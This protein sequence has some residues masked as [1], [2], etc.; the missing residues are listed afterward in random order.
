VGSLFENKKCLFSI[1]V[2]FLLGILVG[3]GLAKYFPGPKP[4]PVPASISGTVWRD[5]TADASTNPHSTCE[6]GSGSAQTNITVRFDIN[7]DGQAGY[8]EVINVP[9]P[10]GTFTLGP[11]ITPG[12]YRIRAMST[13]GSGWCDFDNQA[14]AGAP[15]QNGVLL[16]VPQTGYSDVSG[17]NFGYK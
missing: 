6:L 13:S 16:T 7:Y 17:V 3:L 5:T 11:S 9:A 12:D 15:F 10:A 4:D 2:G 14:A 8:D 1:V